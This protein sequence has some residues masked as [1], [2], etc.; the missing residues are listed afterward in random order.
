M[1]KRIVLYTFLALAVAA[2]LAWVKCIQ[3]EPYSYNQGL[4]DKI[5]GVT[6]KVY[7]CAEGARRLSQ[8]TGVIVKRYGPVYEVLTARHLEDP[9][10]KRYEIRHPLLERPVY[11]GVIATNPRYDLMLL[12]FLSFTDLP[13][14]P[15]A[16][17]EPPVSTK[18]H[19]YG[20]GAKGGMMFT[21]G[22]I[23]SKGGS[24]KFPYWAWVTTSQGWFG[25]SGGGVFN[26]DCE[27]LGICSRM[28]YDRGHII[29]WQIG[30]VALPHIRSFLGEAGALK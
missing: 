15:I 28:P 30:F 4:Y 1:R 25:D 27:L 22:N 12:C 6:V 7:S 17:Y 16:E 19:L 20:F 26:D 29:A 21:T 24:W 23:S 8:G 3:T 10:T 11:A 13:V 2:T 9:E 18:T 5:S 14:A